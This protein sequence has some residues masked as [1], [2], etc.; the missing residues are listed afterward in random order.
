LTRINTRISEEVDVIV[1]AISIILVSAA[2]ILAIRP[3]IVIVIYLIC[4]IAALV[5]IINEP[6]TIVIRII[7]AIYFAW[8]I[9]RTLGRLTAPVVLDTQEAGVR[10]SQSIPARRSIRAIIISAIFKGIIII[11]RGIPTNTFPSD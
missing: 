11:I 1:V 5:I 6:I 2:I 8:R 9:L 7:P 4:T 10:A 3:S